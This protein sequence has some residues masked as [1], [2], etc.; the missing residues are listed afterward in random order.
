LSTP[1]SQGFGIR[2]IAILEALKAILI[3]VTGFGLLALVHRDVEGIAANIVR[4][5]HI[6]PAS[7]YPQIFLEASRHVS[8]FHLRMLALLALLDAILRG[9]EAVGLWLD[10][11]WGKWLGVVTGAV[12]IPFEVYELSLRLTE[13]RL[14]ALLVNLAIVAYLAYSIRR[15]SRSGPT[16]FEVGCGRGFAR[17]T[18]SARML[19]MVGLVKA[20]DPPY[21]LSCFEKALAP[22]SR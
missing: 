15:Q 11:P 4:R 5:L 14:A 16:P 21:G 6:N 1:S 9:I 18:D 22:Q 8:D 19:V 2:A 3:L 17:P 7:R 10:R 20:L 12:Y 13:F